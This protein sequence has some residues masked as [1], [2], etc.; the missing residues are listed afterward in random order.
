MAEKAR[1]QSWSAERYLTEL[2]RLELDSREEKRL[3]RHLKESNLPV[4]KY[5]DGYD[6]SAVGG[7]DKGQ[8]WQLANHREGKNRR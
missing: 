5:L 4:G 3:Q 8:V 6:F 1:E 7:I 2:C